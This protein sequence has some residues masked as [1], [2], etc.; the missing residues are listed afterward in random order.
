MIPELSEAVAALRDRNTRSRVHSL[1][2]Q[3]AWTHARC[4]RAMASPMG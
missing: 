4:L 3:L 1:R 2:D